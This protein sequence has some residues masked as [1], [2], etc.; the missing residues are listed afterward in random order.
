MLY[1]AEEK[2]QGES[3]SSQLFVTNIAYPA[4]FFSAW[5]GGGCFREVKKGAKEL[6]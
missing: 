1:K 6:I 5:L 3:Q 4:C 2:K